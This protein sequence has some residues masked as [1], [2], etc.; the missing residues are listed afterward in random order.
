M[1][2]TEHANKYW[3]M[4]NGQKIRIKDMEDSHL[5]NTINL[6]IRLGENER[7]R[8][9]LFYLTCPTPTGDMACDCFDAEFEGVMESTYRD[10]LFA[11]AVKRGIF[12]KIKEISREVALCADIVL[13][14]K[15]SKKGK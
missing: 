9:N 1:S 2:K 13:L 3:K 11:E 7:R 4:K 12:D 5:I 6:L 15:I 8:T 14:D 10:D